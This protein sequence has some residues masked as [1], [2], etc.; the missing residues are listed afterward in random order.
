MLLLARARLKERKEASISLSVAWHGIV[1]AVCVAYLLPLCVAI[2]DAGTN[3]A[4]HWHATAG[5]GDDDARCKAAVDHSHSSSI[6]QAVGEI[7]ML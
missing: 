7:K 2:A 3:K 4:L 1:L 5:A 6:V